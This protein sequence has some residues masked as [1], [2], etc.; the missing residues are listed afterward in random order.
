MRIYIAALPSEPLWH[1]G[2]QICLEHKVAERV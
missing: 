2:M 1:L